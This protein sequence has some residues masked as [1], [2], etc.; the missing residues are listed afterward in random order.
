MHR[1]RA[2]V[3]G[4]EELGRLRRLHYAW[5]QSPGFLHTK[6]RMLTLQLSL[7][8]VCHMCKG[9]IAVRWVKPVHSNTHDPNLATDHGKLVHADIRLVMRLTVMLHMIGITLTLEWYLSV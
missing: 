3:S 2:I 4:I 7:E 6:W 9:T 8:R 5:H 1:N